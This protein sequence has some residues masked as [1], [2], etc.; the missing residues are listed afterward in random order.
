MGYAFVLR[1]SRLVYNI[2]FK[3]AW[4]DNFA[5]S[6]LTELLGHDRV[7]RIERGGGLQLSEATFLGKGCHEL[8]LAHSFVSHFLSLL[9]INR[10]LD[11]NKLIT[12]R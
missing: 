10:F 8:G 1:R 3:Q 12:S 7:D 2:E 5:G 9:L 4:E 11:D 6:A